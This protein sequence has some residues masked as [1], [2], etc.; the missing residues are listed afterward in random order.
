MKRIVLTT[1]FCIAFVT[2]S[3]ADDPVWVEPTQDVAS[4][5]N[6][7][8]AVQAPVV[9]APVI[10]GVSGDYSLGVEDVL[11]INILQPEKMAI[12]VAVAPDGSVNVPYI[13]RVYVKG[14][15]LADIQSEIQRRLSDGYMMYPVVSVTLRESRSRKFSIYGQISR[16]GSYP[17]TD[18]KLTVLGAISLAGGFTVPGSSG[19]VKV[20]RPK[21]DGTTEKI[22][23]KI[24]NVMSSGKDQ[25]VN[26]GDTLMVLEDKFFVYGEVNRPG[27][28][29]LED[30]ITVLRAV[31]MAGGFT[32]PGASGRI[33]IIRPATDGG[34]FELIEAQIGAVPKQDDKEAHIIIKSGDTIMVYEDKFF[35]YGEVNR[36]GPYPLEESTTVLK[37]I[38]MA[39]GFSKFGSSSRV[40]CL[41]PY[42]YKPGY[43]TIKLKVNEIMDGNNE[44]DMLLKTGDIIVVSE[45]VF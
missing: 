15:S 19:V 42:D 40:K 4:P 38:S 17:V 1:L 22:D 30:N 28:Y 44:E 7:T 18:D 9:T 24:N 23:V 33:K 27:P 6:L 37:A 8:L 45:G 16:P 2:P 13:G 10:A 20:V 25:F 32:R 41:R 21:A 39:G 43:Q 5:V 34:D 35:V 12:T 29:S 36:P 14:F 31:A 26:P 11:D 3:F